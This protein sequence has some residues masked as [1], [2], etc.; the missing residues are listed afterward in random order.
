MR[1]TIVTHNPFMYA[2]GRPDNSVRVE[3]SFEKRARIQGQIDA[4]DKDLAFAIKNH[5]A[6]SVLSLTLR[7]NRLMAELP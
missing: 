7:R 1:Q 5:R 2:K 6:D 3:A 4:I